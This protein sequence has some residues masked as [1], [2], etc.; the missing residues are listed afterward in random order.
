MGMTSIKPDGRYEYRKERG[1]TPKRSLSLQ[2]VGRDTWKRV[3]QA[4]VLIG[5]AK[6]FWQAENH[7]RQD[8]FFAKKREGYMPSFFS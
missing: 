4:N 3:A 5:N 8:T 6:D 2:L 7:P 1:N